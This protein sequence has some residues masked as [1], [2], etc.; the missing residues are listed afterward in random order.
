MA[1]RIK[2]VSF[3]CSADAL[4]VL[5]QYRKGESDLI[6]RDGVFYLIATCD[7]PETVS[8]LLRGPKAASMMAR[9]PQATS[10]VRQICG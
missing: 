10:A 4:K 5:Q 7:V 9:V 3:V 8:P 6:E 1:G 2:N